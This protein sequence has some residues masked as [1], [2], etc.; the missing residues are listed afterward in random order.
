[1]TVDT[2]TVQAALN[3]IR[4]FLQRDGGDIELVGV[5]DN[6]ARVRLTGNCAG[7]PSAAVTLYFGVEAFL[8]EQIPDLEGIQVV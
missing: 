2:A 8:R 5:V 3:R 1:V 6:R 4:P 7:C